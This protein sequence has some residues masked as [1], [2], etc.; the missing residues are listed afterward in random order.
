M[1]KL[2]IRGG[3]P[4]FGSIEVDSSKNA[5]LP[6]IAAT[7]LTNGVTTLKRVPRISDIDNLLKILISLGIKAHFKNGD[8][9]VDTRD[10]TYT[11][12]TGDTASKIRGSI[13]VLGAILGRFGMASIPYPGGCAIGSRPID[14]HLQGLRDLGITVRE[15]NETIY[16]TRTTK[17][18]P[19]TTDIYLDFPSVGA[20]ENFILASVIGKKRVRIFGAAREPEV[21]DLCN[22]LISCG[23]TICGAGTSTVTIQG[24][25]ALHGTTYTAI[26]D[27]INTGSYLIATA[28]CGGEVTLKNTNPTHNLNLISKL[29][30]AGCDIA[31]DATT[32]TIKST[33]RPRAIGTVQTAAFPGF[34]TDLQSQLSVLMSIGRGTSAI[35]ENLFENRFQHIAELQKL[36]GKYCI[37]GRTVTITGVKELCA[38][39]D[40]A[41]PTNLTA[42]DLRGG[43]ALT[44]AALASQ[45]TTIVHNAQYIYRGHANIE[46]D[47]V[48]LG[49]N[50]IRLDF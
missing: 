18:M 1:S 2:Q 48:A 19:K 4:L 36:G 24:V 21:E 25:R 5:L 7:I 45:G 11:E 10:I 30:K 13:F 42:S 43:V 31:T 46:R 44:I 12:V 41:N 33:K 35:T 38:S 26:P 22:F 40:E 14:L 28:V 47:L 15:K 17:P 32:I 23:A 9:I 34:P 3:A 37:R 8:L 16:C 49:A 50:V 27:R 39:L 29:R 6:I 20:T